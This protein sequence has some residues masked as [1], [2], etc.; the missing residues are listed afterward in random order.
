MLL[1]EVTFGAF[2]II[3]LSFDIVR[4]FFVLF[5]CVWGYADYAVAQSQRLVINGLNQFS[6]KDAREVLKDHWTEIEKKGLTSSLADDAAF[7]LRIGLRQQGFVD[8]DVMSRILSAGVLELKVEEGQPLVLGKI[9][10]TGVDKLD[11]SLLKESM[12]AEMRKRQSFLESSDNLPFVRSSIERGVRAIQGYVRYEGFL[13]A[14]AE[15]VS[16]DPPDAKRRIDVHVNVSEGTQSLIRS[17]QTRGLEPILQRKLR[18][19]GDP[20]VKRPVNVA[21]TRAIQGECLRILNELGYFDTVVSI[22]RG[23]PSPEL[24]ETEVDVI[25]NVDAGELYRLTSVHVEGGEALSDDFVV[26]RF[27]SMIGERYDPVEMRQVY[28]T[29]IQ[30]GLYNDL[31]LTPKPSG[32]GE[33]ILDVK[34]EEAKFRQLGLYGGFGSFDGY[35]LGTAYTNRNLFGTG[36][37][38]RSALEINGRGVHGEVNYLD[39]WFMDS[40]W[41]LGVKIHSSTREYDGYTK[42]EIGASASISYE[43]SDHTALGFYGRFTHVNLTEESFVDVE[44]GPSS[45]QVQELGAV[46]TWDHREDLEPTGHGY[47]FELSLDYATSFLIGDVSLLKSQMRLAHYWKLPGDTELRV[48]MRAGVMHP[49]GGAKVIPVDLRFFNGGSQSIR[50]F[51]ERELGPQDRRRHPIGGQFYTILNAEFIVPLQDSFSL[52]VFGDAGNLLADSS[53]Y[54]FTEMHYAAGLGLRYDLPIG[55]LRVDYGFNLNRQR[56]EPKGTLHIGFGFAF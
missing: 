22:A 4:S 50:S 21:N 18:N 19:V 34:V 10:F 14:E 55:P 20:Y 1:W 40:E 12:V 39:R 43:I 23:T 26:K 31:E 37:S 56:G 36:R 11:E 45:Y 8:A 52:A 41:Q 17:V 25:V 9:V 29:L 54:G 44:I 48:G 16:I 33:M 15:L 32:D 5:I 47:F 42:W 2:S 38:L 6:E 24:I 51:P 13:R 35:I 49:L 7:F 30:T 27:K 46:F 3:F 53:E 28:R